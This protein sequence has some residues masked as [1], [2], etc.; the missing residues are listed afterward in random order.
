MESYNME[1]T[2][3]TYRVYDPKRIGSF[4][5]QARDLINNEIRLFSYEN[6][7]RL[8]NWQHK[9]DG[10]LKDVFLGRKFERLEQKISNFGNL[11]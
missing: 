2:E 4:G 11:D 10:E 9:V 5:V 8:G 3:N 7:E 6:L 1:Y